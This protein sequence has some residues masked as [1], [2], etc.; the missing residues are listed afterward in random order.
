MIFVAV[1]SLNINHSK[2]PA[3]KMT[4]AHVS[5]T[6]GR[7]GHALVRSNFTAVMLISRLRGGID[8]NEPFSDLKGG[9]IDN[10]TQHGMNKL[11]KAL[12][13]AV[14]RGDRNAIE[15]LLR[16]GASV[17]ARDISGSCPLH[18]A[19]E[20]GQIDAVNILLARVRYHVL[21]V[22]KATSVVLPPRCITAQTKM[23]L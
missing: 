14:M 20:K 12:R 22:L 4:R 2:F 17:N 7:V 6:R 8:G 18:L 9:P 1:S 11:S 16:A 10:S 13:Y 21:Q 3:L 15:M 5:Y 23:I 19:A